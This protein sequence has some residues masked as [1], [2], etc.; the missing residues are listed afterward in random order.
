VPNWIRDAGHFK[1]VFTGGEKKPN[2]AGCEGHKRHCI[3]E[4]FRPK[5]KTAGPGIRIGGRSQYNRPIFCFIS[6]RSTTIWG[7]GKVLALF[8]GYGPG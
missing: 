4:G 3:W 2:W 6:C 8:A 5:V 1:A 7:G